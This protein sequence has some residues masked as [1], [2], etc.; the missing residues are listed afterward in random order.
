MSNPGVN[1]GVGSKEE[2]SMETEAATIEQEIPMHERRW[3]VETDFG[4]TSPAVWYVEEL[5]ELQEHVERGPD[6]NLIEKITITLN[7]RNPEFD[8]EQEVARLMAR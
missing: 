6:W 1:G 5:E 4:G 7:R 2:M 8:R 3:R